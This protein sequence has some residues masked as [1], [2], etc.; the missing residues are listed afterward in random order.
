[1]KTVKTVYKRLYTETVGALLEAEVA[2]LR[3]QMLL[4]QQA[5]EHAIS[6]NMTGTPCGKTVSTARFEL[7][8]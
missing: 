4:N 3:T 1:M 2:N 6:Y 5:F 8:G 7:E